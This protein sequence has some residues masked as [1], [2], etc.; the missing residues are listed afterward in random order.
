MPTLTSSNHSE[1]STKPWWRRWW[2]IAGAVVLVLGAVANAGDDKDSSSTSAPPATTTSSTADSTTT[3][4]PVTLA[5]TVPRPNGG[6]RA[7]LEAELSA[8]YPGA[9]EGKYAD[10]AVSVCSDILRG[11][12]GAELEG[13]VILRFSGGSR[14]DPTPEQARQMIAVIQANG[15]CTT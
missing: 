1:P 7:S 4:T 6:Q 10:W 11:A 13:N 3:T 14:P 9:P 5:T 15:F 2:V 8:I 12:D